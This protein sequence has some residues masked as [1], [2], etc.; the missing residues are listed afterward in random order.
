MAGQK[1]NNTEQP[2]RWAR[3]LSRRAFV[4]SSAGALALL[5][6][7]WRPRPAASQEIRRGFIRPI[8]PLFIRP[9]TR[10]W[11]SVGSVHADA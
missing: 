10:V 8:R 6:L 1:G 3:L 4:R 7:P 9:W 2:E 11:S 5:A